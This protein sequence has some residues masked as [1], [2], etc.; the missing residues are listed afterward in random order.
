[1]LVKESRRRDGYNVLGAL[2][3]AS[4]ALM[5]PRRLE[6][7]E[8]PV[9]CSRPARPFVIGAPVGPCPLEDLEVPVLGSYRA[10]S[11][12]LGVPLGPRPLEHG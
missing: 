2:M 12:F 8:E 1:M 10:Y 9:C 6:D 4:R 7:L 11:F 5:G 3:I